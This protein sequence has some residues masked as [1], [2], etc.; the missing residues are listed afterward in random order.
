MR[1]REGDKMDKFDGGCGISHRS[2]SKTRCHPGAAGRDPSRDGATAARWLGLGDLAVW[3]GISRWTAA[4]AGVTSGVGWVLSKRRPP[5]SL[6][7]LGQA[8]G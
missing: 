2:P 7:P 5:V 1:Q 8:Q 3:G 4:C 6:E